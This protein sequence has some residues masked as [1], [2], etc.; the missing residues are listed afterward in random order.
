MRFKKKKHGCAGGSWLPIHKTFRMRV[1]L[2]A[3]SCSRS[4]ELLVSAAFRSRARIRL[5]S[6]ALPATRPHALQLVS[7]ERV[8]NEVKIDQVLRKQHAVCTRAVLTVLE[9][10]GHATLSSVTVEHRRT[11]MRLLVDLLDKLG[12]EPV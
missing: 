1:C 6:T 7:R 4:R 10:V 5:Q 12:V 2:C 11:I 3:I 9:L 8:E